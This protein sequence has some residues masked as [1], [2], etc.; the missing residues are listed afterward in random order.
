MLGNLKEWETISRK[1]NFGDRLSSTEKVKYTLSLLN[2]GG[3]DWMSLIVVLQNRYFVC[4]WRSGGT[5]P[6]HKSRFSGRDFSWRHRTDQK[7]PHW[8]WLMMHKR[9]SKWEGFT[10]E[11]DLDMK[12]VLAAARAL[13]HLMHLITR[14]LQSHVCTITCT[15]GILLTSVRTFF[16]SEREIYILCFHSIPSY[17]Y[18]YVYA[19]GKSEEPTCLRFVVYFNLLCIEALNSKLSYTS[20]LDCNLSALSIEL[21]LEVLLDLLGS[22]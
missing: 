13:T 8:S 1:A 10:F 2:K 19:G 4:V 5:Y 11:S 18:M 21:V 16:F 9:V 20:Y 22:A 3:L 15:D 14:W 17:M 7:L 6:V 12:Q